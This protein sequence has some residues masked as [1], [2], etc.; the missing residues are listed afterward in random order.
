MV[1][2]ADGVV[3]AA[4]AGTFVSVIALVPLEAPLP[5][6]TSLSRPLV[7]VTAA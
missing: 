5:E 2:A 3:V 7:A 4:V 1:S 6:T